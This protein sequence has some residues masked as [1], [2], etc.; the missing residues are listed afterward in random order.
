MNCIY[1]EFEVYDGK[2]IDLAAVKRFLND[3]IP[4][5]DFRNSYMVAFQRCSQLSMFLL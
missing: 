3:K 2:T 4:D 1:T 5:E